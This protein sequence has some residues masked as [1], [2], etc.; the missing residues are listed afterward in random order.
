MLGGSSARGAP[1]SGRAEGSSDLKGKQALGVSYSDI[2]LL[3]SYA[4][5]VDHV[6]A[7]EIVPVAIAFQQD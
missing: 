4:G 3:A 6:T 1:L 7:G 5:L 2:W